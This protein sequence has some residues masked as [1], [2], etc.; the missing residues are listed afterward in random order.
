MIAQL[1]IMYQIFIKKFHC[2]HD[3]ICGALFNQNTKAC[4]RY[5]LQSLQ[6]TCLK[7]KQQTLVI[8]TVS[9]LAYSQQIHKGN[10]CEE[11]L[12]NEIKVKTR[13]KLAHP[14]YYLYHL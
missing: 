8:T 7:T 13:L 4:S 11:I 3:N 1:A 6:N 5:F 14:S 10:I 9:K 2:N 12:H